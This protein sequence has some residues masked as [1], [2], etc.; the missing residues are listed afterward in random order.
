MFDM[1][2]HIASL[3][4][5]FLAL[6][7]GLLLGSLI[8]DKGILASQQERIMKSIAADVDKIGEQNAELR[9][10]LKELERFQ[11]QVL[12]IAVKDR[13]T[14]K[15]VVVATFTDE[16]ADLGRSIGN[17][18]SSAGATAF[19]LNIQV[20]KLD[21][22]DTDLVASLGSEFDETEAQ[23][24]DFERRFWDRLANEM[25][26][27]EPATLTDAL[28]EKDLIS[29]DTSSIPVENIVIV[30]ATKR[31]ARNR[32]LFFLESLRQADVARI[33]GVEDRDTKPSRVG[34]YKLRNIS[35]VDNIDEV[36]GKISLSYLLLNPDV[37]AY[38]GIKSTADKFLP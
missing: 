8:V 24:G 16:Q 13:L 19:P 28:I 11:S 33:V 2:Y 27:R 21:F 32:D 25:V 29:F 15:Q 35:T 7:I 1:R 31:Q 4:A 34:A 17:M 23:G 12:P 10:R 18:I 30:A 5:V 22:S 3:V 20:D 36:A 38:Y 14:D 9:L 26:G 37:T 6:T